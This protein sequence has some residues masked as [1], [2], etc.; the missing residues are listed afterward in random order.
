MVD[1]AT[2]RKIVYMRVLSY[3]NRINIAEKNAKKK[4]Y[5]DS[6]SRDNDGKWN[7]KI[8]KKI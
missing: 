8:K 4:S 1:N 6:D 2:L 3:W 5:G 7:D